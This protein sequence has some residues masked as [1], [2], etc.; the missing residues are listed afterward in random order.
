VHINTEGIYIINITIIILHYAQFFFPDSAK[1]KL[2]IVVDS[3]EI[4][5]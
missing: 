5:K 2:R 3:R 4:T 1:N